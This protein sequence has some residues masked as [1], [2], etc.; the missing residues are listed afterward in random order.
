M[1]QIMSVYISHNHGL[2]MV[3]RHSK[4]SSGKFSDVPVSLEFLLLSHTLVVE[5][6]PSYQCTVESCE[7]LSTA[8]FGCLVFTQLISCNCAGAAAAF[9]N[10]P[11]S[12]D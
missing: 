2:S 6:K 7:L 8:M 4:T 10:N 12:L 11:L 1:K 9:V 3:K 5:V